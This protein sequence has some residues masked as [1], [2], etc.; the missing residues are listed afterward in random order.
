M[1]ESYTWEE[2]EDAVDALSVALHNRGFTCIA[3]I[4]RGGCIPAALVAHK[5]GIQ[6]VDYVNYSRAYGFE[7][8]SLTGR[9]QFEDVLFI[10]DA[11]ET[12]S[13]MEFIKARYGETASVAVLFCAADNQTNRPAFVG[14]DYVGDCPKMPWEVRKQL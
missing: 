1:K 7:G 8:D 12:G 9:H 6:V 4:G 10:D 3:A 14:L 2:V 13:T 5:L 11:T